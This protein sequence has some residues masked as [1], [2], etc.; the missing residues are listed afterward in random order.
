LYVKTSLFKK[1]H[2]NEF[3]GKTFRARE[4]FLTSRN[5]KRGQWVYDG[6]E[7]RL[8]RKMRK[9]VPSGLKVTLS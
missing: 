8:I 4:R 7:R 1:S 5:V 3:I 6:G 9:R 2:T